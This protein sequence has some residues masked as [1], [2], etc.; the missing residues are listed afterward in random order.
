MNNI[1][2]TKEDM[3]NTLFILLVVFIYN[4]LFLEQISLEIAFHKTIFL[5]DYIIHGNNVWWASKEELFWKRLGQEVLFLAL[6]YG[7]AISS[8][9][10]IA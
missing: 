8:N 7:I 2:A 3:Q 1:V 5:D 6:L 4:G 10:E 9:E